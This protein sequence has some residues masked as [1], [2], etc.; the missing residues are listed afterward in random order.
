MLSSSLPFED[1]YVLTQPISAQGLPF[2][3][4]TSSV[5]S[6]LTRDFQMVGICL[7]WGF[8]G[9]LV[10]QLCASELHFASAVKNLTWFCRL[11]SP[12]FSRRHKAHQG[13]WYATLHH[14]SSF[15]H[16]RS[17]RLVYSL[18][19]LDTVQT[20]MVTADAFHWF[21][22][23]YGNMAR[24]DD[25]FLNSWDVCLLDAVISLIV[26]TFYCWRI[27]V[28]RGRSFVIPGAILL[29]SLPSISFFPF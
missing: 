7:N 14:V 15:P 16:N 8:M 1:F 21:V 3:S 20:A 12:Q 23:G 26:Q 2:V 19:I 9:V 29:V 11:L 18:A 10:V 13:S 22:F 27:Y 5:A 4:K 17:S 6:S 25:T 28:L 24:L